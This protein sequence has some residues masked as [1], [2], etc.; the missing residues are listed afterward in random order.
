M[1]KLQGKTAVITGGT[2]GIGLAVAKLFAAEGALVFITGRR[3]KE[4]DDA[5]KE[6]GDNACG[7]QGDVASLPDLD[8]LYET[9]AARGRIDVVV[10]NA[11]VGGFASLEAVTEEY[12]D[13]IFSTNVKGALSPTKW[14]GQRCSWPQTTQASSPE[15]SY[16][17]TAAEHKS[18]TAIP[19]DTE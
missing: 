19:Q 10:A 17:S 12:F 3:Q 2:S 18:D 14:P 6:I 8:R 15:P 7:V 11:G 5:V 1:G 13:R 9:I 4:L 16:S